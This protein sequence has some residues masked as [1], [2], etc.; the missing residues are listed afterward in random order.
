MSRFIKDFSSDDFNLAIKFLPLGGA[1]EIG[2]NCYYLNVSGTGIILDCGMH[3]Q[4]TGR[5]SLPSLDIIEDKQLDHVLISHA[6]Q[7]HLGALPFLIKRH[8]YLRITTTPQTR[9]LA[10]VTLHNAISILKEQINEAEK[11]DLYTH[12]EID[13]LIRSIDYKAYNDEFDISGYSFRD[14][15]VKAQFYDAGHI[16]GAAGILIESEGRK[17]FY[18]G[19]INV[20]NQALTPGAD[21]PQTKIDTLIMETTY[22]D[23]DSSSI[24][25]WNDEAL[26]FARSV[27]K[28][29]N[30][31]GSILIPV[32]SLGKMQEILTTIWNLM[33]S[34]KM[35]QTE[36]YTGG[37]A[38]KIS[39]IYD[40]NRYS[41]RRINPELEISS[42]PQ[43]D[44]YEVA[45]PEKLFKNPCIVLA[46]SGM[47]IE[48]TASY[49]L[50]KYWIK[51]SRSAIFTVGY[52][53]ASTPGYK[54]SNSKK[55]DLI[56]LNEFTSEEIK[57]SIEKFRF[58]SHSR[59]EGL[60]K[61]VRRLQPEKIILVHGEPDGISWIGGE[62]KKE[63]KS[64]KLYA[65]KPGKEI[66]I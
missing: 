27:N 33:C 4:K 24:L 29:L 56:Q 23:T 39:R 28:V 30:D 6:H 65:A 26:R 7:D 43:N 47:M 22:G 11:L 64:V 38:R 55:G 3:P 16:L 34:G 45:Q 32:F 21:L 41:I 51:Q 61:I 19:D 18:T 57:C 12:E 50:A 66:D 35:T 36:I 60:L 40:Y 1:E 48:G 46:S 9:A 10:E 13:L 59:R 37:V 52:M 15:K 5:E 8:P 63:F 58:P 54:F 31:G 20:D 53:E 2:A 62:I 17:I 25:R 44:L 42:I 14:G 49:N